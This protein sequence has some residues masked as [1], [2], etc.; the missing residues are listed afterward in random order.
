MLI[1]LYL[2][3]LGLFLVFEL[4]N[5]N[6]TL[7]KVGTQPRVEGGS[8]LARKI[9]SLSGDLVKPLRFIVCLKNNKFVR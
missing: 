3:I 5:S 9:T 7:R 8:L 6:S 1:L 2:P 4:V